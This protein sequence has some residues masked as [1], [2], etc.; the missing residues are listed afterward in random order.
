MGWVMEEHWFV[1][2]YEKLA[3][4]HMHW[5]LIVGVLAMVHMD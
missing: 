3:E 2:V 5:A 4:G 1:E